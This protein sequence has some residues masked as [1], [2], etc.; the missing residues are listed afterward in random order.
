MSRIDLEKLLQPISEVA[1]CGADTEYDQDFGE[2]LRLAQGEPEKQFGSTIVEAIPPNWAEVRSYALGLSERTKDVRVASYLC[3]A[4]LSE[5][6]FVGFRDSLKLFNEYIRRF[7]PTIHPQLDPDDDNDPTIRVNAIRA[8]VDPAS[9]LLLVRT[10]PIVSARAFGRFSYR[11]FQVARGDIPPPASMQNPPKMSAIEG[12]VQA[13]EGA[14]LLQTTQAVEECVTLVKELDRSVTEQTGV[15]SGPDLTALA[16][17][18]AAIGKVMRGW[19]N[20]RGISETAPAAAVTVAATEAV[21]PATGAVAV[22]QVVVR[23]PGEISSR[24]EAIE[25]LDK[26]CQW[27]EKFEPSSPLPLLLKRAKRLSTKS[28]MEIL[29]D[30]TPDGLSQA[31]AIG[32]GPNGQ[33]EE[34]KSEE[35]PQANKTK[36]VPEPPRNVHND[37]Y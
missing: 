22:A 19:L 28:F 26:I 35:P 15:G 4:M 10:V 23:S 7:W 17:E 12:A 6:G 1:P 14:E 3:R 31:Q 20:E 30:L 16:K 36:Y 11:D 25:A 27:F 2:M 21:G 13:S 32:F 29:R 24:Q 5:A 18:L 37:G 34:L 8:L 33:E 9:T